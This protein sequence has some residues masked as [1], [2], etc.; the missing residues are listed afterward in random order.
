MVGYG[1]GY[2]KVWWTYAHTVI[3]LLTFFAGF[4]PTL[5][6]NNLFRSSLS[7]MTRVSWYRYQKNIHSLTHCLSGCYTTSLLNFLHFSAVH[8]TFLSYL[9]GQSYLFCNLAPSFLWSA[10]RSYTLHF[11]IHEFFHPV[12]FIRS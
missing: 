7:R 4:F 10:S 6:N 12:I 1:Y 9:S 3:V 5:N 8:S 11:K 2:E